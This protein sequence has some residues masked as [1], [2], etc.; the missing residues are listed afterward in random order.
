[1][2][3]PLAGWTPDTAPFDA[4]I[5]AEI[6]GIAK[7]VQSQERLATGDGRDAIHDWA[8]ALTELSVAMTG[9]D[10]AAVRAAAEA[11]QAPLTRLKAVCKFDS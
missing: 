1:M 7:D 6:R 10:K 5:A 4:T 11:V 3:R 8:V 2:R 9:K